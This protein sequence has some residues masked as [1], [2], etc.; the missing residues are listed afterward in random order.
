MANEVVRFINEGVR[1]AAND[2]AGMYYTMRALKD[3][4]DL[5]EGV[6]N[7]INVLTGKEP[8]DDGA[9]TDGRPVATPENVKSF[10]QTLTTFLET[11]EAD[12]KAQLHAIL[13]L[14]NR[15]KV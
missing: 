13:A 15:Y 2:F 12:N 8:I 6:G 7:V 9:V 11:M 10:I 4:L 3:R 1:P 14:S 5:P